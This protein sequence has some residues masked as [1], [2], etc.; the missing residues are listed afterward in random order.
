MTVQ[1]FNVIF[2]GEIFDDREPEVVKRMLVSQLGMTTTAVERFFTLPRVVVKS[3]AD[4]ETAGSLVRTFAAL[5]VV[6]H[7]EPAASPGLHSEDSSVQ[8]TNPESHQGVDSSLASAQLCP[9]CGH[10]QPFA[11]E[12]ACCG[13]IFS[14]V[15]PRDNDRAG[16]SLGRPSITYYD[17]VREKKQWILLAILLIILT[18]LLFRI[19]STRDIKHPPGI[20]VAA[21][22]KQI[23]IQNP[24]PWHHR[25][26]LVVPLARFSLQARVLSTERYHFDNVADLSPIDVALGWGPM[27]DQRILDQLEVVQDSRCFVVSPHHG[28]P[29]LPMGALLV[30]SSNMH[31]L[32]ANDDIKDRLLSL[33]RGNIVELNG[34]LV[35]I[36]ENGQWTWVSSASRTDT[37]NGACEIVWVDGLKVR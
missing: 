14:K 20:L 21:E 32:P 33:R 24:Q 27:S 11:K 2:L 6:C 13:V 37:G 19:I 10:A 29:P 36:Q 35:G 25:N 3:N 16:T 26:R 12:C 5:G 7:L 31:M 28:R 23:N 30:S 8:P 34:Y 15:H 1:R 9:K 22:P 18:G 4:I 17:L